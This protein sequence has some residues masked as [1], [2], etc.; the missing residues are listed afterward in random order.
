TP[1][2]EL[3]GL[4]ACIG[5]TFDVQVMAALAHISD[6][7][8]HATLWPALTEGLLVP[9]S[10]GRFGKSDWRSHCAFVHD[11]MQQAAYA[12]VSDD[13]RRVLPLR[14]GRLLLERTPAA[15]LETEIFDIVMHLNAA[16][17]LV[18]DPA[19]RARIVELNLQA[20]RRAKAATAYKAAAGNFTTA[21][22]LLAED[23]WTA[24]H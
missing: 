18:S 13:E 22:E 4:A 2:Q 16:L 10:G 23:S 3:L 12:V 9:A 17:D 15:Q 1:T 14:L 19:E 8:A 21:M 6:D 7:E 5:N 20:G 24:Q 11:R